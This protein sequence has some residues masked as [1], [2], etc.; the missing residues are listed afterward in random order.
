MLIV[1]FLLLS[2]IPCSMDGVADSSMDGVVHA[3]TPGSVHQPLLCTC[4]NSRSIVN[5]QLD[6]YAMLTAS[7]PDVVVIT[8]TFLDCSIMDDEV[9]PQNYCLFRCDRNR[10]GG[11][12]L[13]GVSDKFPVVCLSDF[14]PANAELLWV[15]IFLGST[16]IILGGFYRPLVS[17]ESCLLELQSSLHCLPHNSQIFLCGDF[18]VL[19]ISWDTF[20]PT[21][22][23]KNAALLCSIAQDF[24]FEQ[25][26]RVPTRGSHVLDLLFTNCPSF[27]SHVDVVDNL[28]HTDH[29]SVI[30]KL[31]MLPPKQE[32]VHRIL[33]NY[34]K[35]DFDAYRDTLRSA[36]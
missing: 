2:L 8:E 25:C 32:R 1:A 23:D 12:V 15:R 14:E 19:N 34:K 6:L 24:A 4:F 7:A 11:G 36:Y 20:S 3:A 29:D 35:A 31:N 17:A 16:S 10:H 22:N 13:I 28:P 26:V 27:V 21:N 9:F 33:Y 5:K 30:F 18:N